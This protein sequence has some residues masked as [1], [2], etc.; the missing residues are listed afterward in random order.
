[1]IFFRII[2]QHLWFCG[3]IYGDTTTPGKVADLMWNQVAPAENLQ[4]GASV[5]WAADPGTTK[6]VVPRPRSNKTVTHCYA[7]F[8]YSLDV[9]IWQLT[10]QTGNCN[11][12]TNKSIK[13]CKLWPIR[14]TF[15]PNEWKKFI[16]DLKDFKNI[17]G[18]E[19]MRYLHYIDDNHSKSRA[20]AQFVK[21]C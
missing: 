18:H 11:P 10:K 2:F 13:K 12:K 16:I 19:V 1:M 3:F 15:R 14:K 17:Q 4:C 21:T 5:Q 9:E 20:Q 8:L 7:I 6:Y